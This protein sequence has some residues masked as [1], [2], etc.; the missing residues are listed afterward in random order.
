MLDPSVSTSRRSSHGLPEAKGYQKAAF[1]SIDARKINS[2]PGSC[3]QPSP[4]PHILKLV[5]T[6]DAVLRTR[7]AICPVSVAV[8]W[9]LLGWTFM[10]LRRL[11]LRLGATFNVGRGLGMGLHS[12]AV[13]DLV[14][15]DMS[16]LLALPVPG[17]GLGTL[18]GLV[19]SAA[20]G[21]I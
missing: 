18:H 13:Y 15:I 16:S 19:S 6:A 7:R 10:L 17:C 8:I 12:R 5:F 4:P 9:S 20:R 1:R 11:V 2:I 14:G 21:G 3:R